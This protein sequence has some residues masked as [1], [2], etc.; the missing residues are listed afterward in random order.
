[1]QMACLYRYMYTKVNIESISQIRKTFKEA[2]DILEKE[3]PVAVV[4]AIVC[5]FVQGKADKRPVWNN[6]LKTNH[7]PQ[8][9][10]LFD[11]NKRLS[12]SIS[13]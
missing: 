13:T 9:L 5:I 12:H 4:A 6:A 11:L 2:V 1:M 7:L 3:I 8:F 10:A